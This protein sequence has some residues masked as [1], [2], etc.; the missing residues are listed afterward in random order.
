MQ[1]DWLPKGPD[2]SKLKTDD[3][4]T[5]LTIYHGRKECLQQT[6]PEDQYPLKTA[7]ELKQCSDIFVGEDEEGDP[8]S[9]LVSGEPGIGKT[10]FSQKLVRDWS[11]NCIS[12]HNI[13]FTYLITFKQLVMLGNEELTLRELLNRSPVLNERTMIDEKVMAHIAQHSDQLFIIFDGYDEYKDRSKMLI[14]ESGQ[15]T[16]DVET[17]MPGAALISKLIQKHILRDS[18]IMITSRPG[19]ADELDK[20]LHFDR[21]VNID[22]FSE[23]L[24][25]EYVKKYFKSKSEDVK[26]MAMEK[27]KGSAHFMSFGRVPLRCF[28]MCVVIEYEIQNNITRDNSIPLKLTQFYCKVIRGL[29]KNNREIR[30]L[31]EKASLLAVEKTLD[32]FSKLAAQLDEQNRFTFTQ[33][34]LE[35]LELPE[36]EMSYL[37]SS[38]LIF[39]YPVASDSPFPQTTLEYGFAHL[40]IQEFFVARHLVKKRAMAARE[41]SE[42]VHIFT[43]GLLGLDKDH[44]NDKSMSKVLKCVCRQV[45]NYW[46]RRLVLLRCLHEYGQEKE[47]TRQELTTNRDYRYWFSDGLIRLHG[48]TDTD[49]DALAM[50]VESIATSISSPPHRL[51]STALLWFTC[52]KSSPRPN[53]LSIGVSQITITGLKSLLSSL[54]HPE[55]TITG[56]GLWNCGLTDEC[57]ECLSN[58]LPDTSITELDLRA[59][60][61][62]NKGVHHVIHHL[63]NNL[64]YLN[65]S[66][67]RVSAEVSES[68]K[69]QS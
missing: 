48:V 35:K 26:N 17:K 64:T 30:S 59:N 47:F 46:R 7:T 3:I 39:C 69:L 29:E 34:D 28:L 22:G 66:F 23:L 8:K 58:C 15:F 5:K 38:S 6:A 31:D 57:A 56:L 55:C 21:F 63:P 33:K 9:I 1:T 11:T 10:L 52:F 32:S 67:N 12:I 20:K 25:L 37:K 50:L 27:V 53:T 14:F 54:I 68:R 61:I 65:L 51:H 45:K 43:S 2:Q 18:V 24:V 13:R 16:N 40:T 36:A 60:E 44:N 19:E 42:M 49:C 4:F 41:T 62:S